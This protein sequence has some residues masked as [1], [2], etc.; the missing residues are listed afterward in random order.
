[1]LDKTAYDELPD[2]V[3]VADD[4]GTVTLVNPAAERMLGV[5][6]DTALGRALRDVLPLADEQGRDWWGC[7]DPYDGLATRSRQPERHLTLPGGRALLVT[8]SYVRD[9]SRRLV[10][11]VVVLR[12]D[13]A[14]E[15]TDRSRADLVSTVAHE[16]RSPLTSVKG[17]TATLL[18]KWDRFDDAQKRLMLET[19]NAD[20]DRV[21][22]LLT[23]LLDVS[24]IDAGRLEMRRQVVDVAVSVRKA[25]A[26]RV[27]SGDPESRFVVDVEDGRPETW[28]DPDKVEQVV[29][30]L[31]E[32]ALRHGA[33]TITLRVRPAQVDGALGTEVTVEDEGPGIPEDVVSRV[34]ARF[35][36]GNRRGG[37][38]LGLYIVKGLVE[39]HGGTVE[40][41]RSASGGARFRFVLPA[42]TAPYDL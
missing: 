6:S 38:G 41:G 15:R 25:V 4:T 11:R 24:R 3:V 29:A 36:R 20:A 2:G 33:G 22:R 19:V 32:N 27:A 37:T 12:D 42:G 16:L 8:A 9:A 13:R 10:R 26:G 30:N 35:W 23:E 40:A 18:A 34:F 17:F 28:A 14:R 21:T 5:T 1:M 39:A 7:T 31:L